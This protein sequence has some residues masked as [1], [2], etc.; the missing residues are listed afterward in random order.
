MLLVN[1]S[2]SKYHLKPMQA[3][4]F[5]IF[6]FFECLSEAQA[7]GES[8]NLFCS[9]E[10]GL[11]Q[12][13]YWL[14]FFFLSI[15]Q[16]PSAAQL[17]WERIALHLFIYLF[18]L[19]LCSMIG[20]EHIISDQR[21]PRKATEQPHDSMLN[22]CPLQFVKSANAFRANACNCCERAP[23]CRLLPSWKYGLLFSSAL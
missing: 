16:G 6:F 2:S 10:P 11:S 7:F 18:P 21:I 9:A 19:L 20:Q 3:F 15:C 5:P 13:S 23:H 4:I 14:F 12:T 8:C 22:I 1:P 17:L